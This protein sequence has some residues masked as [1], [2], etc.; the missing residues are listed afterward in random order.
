MSVLT[1]Y[2]KRQKMIC[3]RVATIQLPGLLRTEFLPGSA[4]SQVSS[5]LLDGQKLQ[6]ASHLWDW[7][8]KQPQLFRRRVLEV[9]V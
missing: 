3:F 1:D 4:P 8:S 9:V 5:N 2:L 6:H 7:V